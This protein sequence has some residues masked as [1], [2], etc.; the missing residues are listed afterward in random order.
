[1]NALSAVVFRDFLHDT[2]CFANMSEFR[3]TIVSKLLGKYIDSARCTGDS[4]HKQR[5]EL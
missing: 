1:M 4:S 5:E 3:A 2:R